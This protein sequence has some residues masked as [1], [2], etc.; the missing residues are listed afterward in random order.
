MFSRLGGS[1]LVLRASASNTAQ[2][3][4]GRLLAWVNSDAHARFVADIL[5]IDEHARDHDVEQ[6]QHVI[7][8]RRFQRP[9]ESER[10][11]FVPLLLRPQ[12]PG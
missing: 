11:V 12:H 6:V 3:H 9:H 2:M 4:V 10:R 7:L 1:G 5:G 8:R